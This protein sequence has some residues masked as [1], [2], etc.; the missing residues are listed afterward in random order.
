MNQNRVY[1]NRAACELPRTAR[2]RTAAAVAIPQSTETSLLTILAVAALL[3]LATATSAISGILDVETGVRATERMALGVGAF[4]IDTVGFEPDDDDNRVNVELTA[5]LEK[6][7][8]DDDDD[9]RDRGGVRKV[10]SEE[11]RTVVRQYFKR[12]S[13]ECPTGM[14]RKED[15]FCAPQQSERLWIIGKPLATSVSMTA[16]PAGLMSS[17]PAAGPGQAYGFINGDIVLYETESRV[18]IDAMTWDS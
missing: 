11:H 14:E 1:G 6:D 13:D 16:V 17:L 5:D 2:R 8:D 3:L 18:V 12:P 4:Q 10:F 9:D 7:D 15:G